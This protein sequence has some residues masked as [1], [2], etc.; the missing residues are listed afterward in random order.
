MAK[1]KDGEVVATVGLGRIL[2]SWNAFLTIKSFLAS[3]YHGLT[4]Q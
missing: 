3:G 4:R 1:H 2:F